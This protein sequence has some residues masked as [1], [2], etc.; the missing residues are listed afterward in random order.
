MPEYSDGGE[1]DVKREFLSPLRR[2][3]IA[4]SLASSLGR[5]LVIDDPNTVVLPKFEDVARRSTFSSNAMRSPISPISKHTFIKT[6]DADDLAIVDEPEALPESNDNREARYL[7]QLRQVVWKQLVPA[8]PDQRDGMVRCSVDILEAA[9]C[10]F[11]PVSNNVLHRLLEILTFLQLHHAMMAVAALSMAVQEGKE[12]LDALQYYQQVLP[13]LQTRL[14][15]P[16]DLAS[17]GAFLTHFMLL[18]YEVRP[19]YSLDLVVC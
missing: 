16:D 14:T 1:P 6:E 11:S 12:R 19:S 18:V 3:S 2:G 13:E 7:Q 9:A 10:T 4:T 17:D 8:E 15:T 5:D